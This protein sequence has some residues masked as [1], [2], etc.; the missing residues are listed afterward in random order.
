MNFFPEICELDACEIDRNLKCIDYQPK[1]KWYFPCYFFK[2]LKYFFN[3]L[4]N[5]INSRISE[6]NY[7]CLNLILL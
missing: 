3:I 4:I 7:T 1:I 5:C 6:L 2:G